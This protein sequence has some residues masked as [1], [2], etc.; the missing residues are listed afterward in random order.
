MF[1]SYQSY[2]SRKGGNMLKS[3]IVAAVLSSGAVSAGALA[4]EVIK[5]KS[6]HNNVDT[7]WE[8]SELGDEP[9]HIRGV[10]RRRR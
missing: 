3:A 7:K 1:A 8:S 6:H 10:M 5:F 2:A 4:G 9:G